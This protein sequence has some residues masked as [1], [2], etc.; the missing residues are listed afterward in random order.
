MQS[1][2][3]T[4]YLSL[5]M[6]HTA[7]CSILQP[8]TTFQVGS[9][10]SEKDTNESFMLHKLLA[11]HILLLAFFIAF[12][13]REYAISLIKQGLAWMNAW[14]SDCYDLITR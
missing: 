12:S 6:T 2:R 5:R 8:L 13:I 11:T 10:G 4:M 14:C 9:P 7:I 3:G 1:A